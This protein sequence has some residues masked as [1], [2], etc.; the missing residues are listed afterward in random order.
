MKFEKWKAVW[1]GNAI[2]R[3]SLARVLGRLRY[4]VH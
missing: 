2:R 4:P 1:R 3:P